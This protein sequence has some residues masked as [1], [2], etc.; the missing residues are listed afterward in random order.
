M[1]FFKIIIFSM[2]ILSCR[3]FDNSLNNPN[4]IKYDKFNDK[5]I[6]SHYYNEALDLHIF[7]DSDW[8]LKIYY[9][10]FDKFEKKYAS[11]IGSEYGEVLFIGQ[12][13]RRKLGIRAVCETLGLSNIEY[14]ESLKEQA[15]SQFN[16]YEI[17]FIQEENV[18]FTNYEGYHIIMEATISENNIFVYDS[19]IFKKGLNNIKIDIWSEKNNYDNNDNKN[20]IFN[21]YNSFDFYNIENFN[22][23]IDSLNNLEKDQ[24]QIIKNF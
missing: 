15:K 3:S 23:N 8:N 2:L 14:F 16:N 6:D 1:K 17:K 19:V 4:K 12:N 24:I 18:T 13:N 10:Y 7:F 9:K 21:I 22:K 20:Y 5:I 11:L